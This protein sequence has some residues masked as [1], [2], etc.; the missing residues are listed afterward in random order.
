MP[1]KDETIVITITDDLEYTLNI[2]VLR[3]FR[4]EKTKL[5]L[6]HKLLSIERRRVQRI[7]FKNLDNQKY[8][9][10]DKGR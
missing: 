10:I 1:Q 6:H 2:R 3:L 7:T 4:D 5:D 8:R 9:L